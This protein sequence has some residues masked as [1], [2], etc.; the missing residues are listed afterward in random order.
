RAYD[1]V[2]HR[3]IS[4]DLAQ[5][6]VL[7]P[8]FFFGLLAVLNV[9]SGRVPADNT[10]VVIFERVISDQEPAI[11]SV[12]ASASLFDFEG[13]PDCESV[14]ALV[15]RPLQIIRVEY[16]LAKLSRSDVF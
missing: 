9:S 14:L 13:L 11:A 10:P 1:F 16:P 4:N 12:A 15:A 6:N 2:E 8:Y 7:V 3:G 5:R